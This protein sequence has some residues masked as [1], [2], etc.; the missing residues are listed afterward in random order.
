MV[1]PL[2]LFK[3]LIVLTLTLPLPLF[4][5]SASGDAL[6]SSPIAVLVGVIIVLGLM[7]L[8]RVHALLGLCF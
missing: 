1:K 7:L 8:L 2:R 4:A 3:L 6:V 5:Q